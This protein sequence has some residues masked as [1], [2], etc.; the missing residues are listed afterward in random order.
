MSARHDE[1]AAWDRRHI[2]LALCAA[3]VCVVGLALTWVMAELV[4]ATR[5]RDA[6]ALHGFIDLGRPWINDVGNVLL[7]AINP[8]TSAVCVA[9]LAA[10]AVRRR[11]PRVALAIPAVVAGAVGTSE[12][13]KPLL[14][15]SHDWVVATRYVTDASWPSGHSAAAM[16][17]AL[18]AVLAAP[19]RWRPFV[20]LVGA[21]FTVLVGFSLLTLAWHMP[22][23]VIGGLLVAGLW[24]SLAVAAVL[25]ARRNREKGPVRR[26]QVGADRS[27]AE[28]RQSGMAATRVSLAL[29]GA[30]ALAL[31][32]VVALRPHQV[33]DFAAVHRSVVVAAAAIA[34][35]AA[36]LPAGLTAGLRR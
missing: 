29:L 20:A 4:P 19:R 5:L 9:L 8:L 30:V 13:L 35:L 1:A 25:A 17:L 15:H 33:A 18:C 34:V 10:V 3:V 24:T 21:A 16:A 26:R 36:A 32:A 23:D 27:L 7:D 14:A 2:K 11:R 31:I 6:A 28:P 12:L 22:S